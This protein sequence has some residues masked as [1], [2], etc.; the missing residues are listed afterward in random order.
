[1]VF[2]SRAKSVTATHLLEP[3]RSISEPSITHLVEVVYDQSNFANGIGF[4]A[5]K[6]LVKLI[7]QAKNRI[8]T[9]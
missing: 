5:A 2:H 4:T 8:H 6:V 1:M 3:L 9:F 7:T